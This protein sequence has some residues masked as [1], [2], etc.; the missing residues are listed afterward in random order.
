MSYVSYK[1]KLKKINLKPDGTKEIVLETADLQGQLETLS[2]MIGTKLEVTHDDEVVT[3]AV[4]INTKT[5][6]PIREYKVDETGVVSE[7][8]PEGEQVELELDG[9]PKEVIET[10]S[11]EKELDKEIIDDFIAAGM[12]PI[13]E[14]MP[15]EFT[16]MVRRLRDG[17]T[18]VKFA[19]ELD[20]TVIEVGAMFD[21]YRKRVA[22]MAIKWDLWRNGKIK[23]EPAV[24]QVTETIEG[25]EPDPNAEQESTEGEEQIPP[26]EE[27]NFET[28][29]QDQAESTD[30]E[31]VK[32]PEPEQVTEAKK[33]VTAVDIDN[34]AL[35]KYIL[36]HKPKFDGIELDFPELLRQRKEEGKTWMNIASVINL[37]SSKLST[38]WKSYKELVAKKMTEEGAA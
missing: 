21:E 4:Q 25:T 15:Y 23:G 31:T 30:Q 7:V 29:E 1:A 24:Q 14:D 12:S 11:E 28:E 2:D 34:E 20:M 5:N 26:T 18:Y 9:V 35:E 10:K 8:K 13:F 17:E 6:K 33:E 38:I 32:T 37:S 3:Y 36:E 16:D 27:V 22:E 19:N